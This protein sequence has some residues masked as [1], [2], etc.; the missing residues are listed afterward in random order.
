MD[1]L[2][3]RIA[4]TRDA[5][6]LACASRD[7]TLRLLNVGD[8]QEPDNCKS[9]SLPSNPCCF[10]FFPDEKS[11]IVSCNSGELHIWDLVA[12]SRQLNG[13][14]GH[15]KIVRDISFSPDGRTFVTVSHDCTAKLWLVA[16]L[17][18]IKTFATHTVG[19][20][21]SSIH[22]KTDQNI[23]IAVFLLSKVYAWRRPWEN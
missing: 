19:L 8:D 6:L 3:D 5:G 4:F 18:C 2:I 16:D 13:R 9:L 10:A 17:S 7:Q 21:F 11:L 20:K 15:G 23:I 14:N 12:S 1:A 22:F